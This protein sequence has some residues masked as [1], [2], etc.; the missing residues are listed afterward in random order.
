MTD[1]LHLDLL[2]SPIAAGLARTLI[3]Q[4][5]TKWGYHHILDDVLLVASELIV[6][7]AE[8]TPNAQIR[9][10]LGRNTRGVFVAVWDSSPALPQA[11][12][13]TEL[14]LGDLDASPNTWDN[15]GGWGLPIVEALS[16]TC[17][18]HPDEQRGKWLWATLV[19]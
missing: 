12:P 13:V 17:G 9:F 10:R 11:K 18:L 15:G 6:N 8:A 3:A 7:A 1:D 2:G 14:T 5:I 16:A 4:R 19:A